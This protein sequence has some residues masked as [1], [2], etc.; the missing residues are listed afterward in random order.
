MAASAAGA[1]APRIDSHQHFWRYRPE[2]HGWIGDPMAILKRDFLPEDLAPLL[3][4]EGFSGCVAVQASQSL[5]ETRFLLDVAES[6]AFVRAVVGWV[7]LRA[8]DLERQLGSFAG[9]KRLRGMRHI[10]QDEADD[11]WL[12]REDVIRG[13]GTL[14]RHG[15]V[16][17]ILVYARQL[18]SAI[19]LA[20]ALPDQPFVLD[21]IAKPEIVRGRLDPWRADLTRLAELPNVSCKLSG[22]VTEARWDGWTPADFRPYLD[23][24]LD[25]FGPGRLMFGSDWPVCLLAGSYADVVGLARGAIAALSRDEQ[26]AV[27]G[28]N[29]A[30]VYGLET[31]TGGTP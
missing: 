17:D 6:H 19:T 21:H 4:A 22:L 27:L 1:V 29:A 28:G 13:V 16:Y 30:R 15:L 26:D 7:D 31:A 14:G 24:A 9:R 10:A 25:A 20:H 12:A 3:E 18:E 11:G 2:T 23:V 5:D 8:A